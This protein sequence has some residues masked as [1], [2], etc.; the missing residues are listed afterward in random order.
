MKL[1][2][3]AEDLCAARDAAVQH[4]AGHLADLALASQHPAEPEVLQWLQTETVTR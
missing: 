1:H 2:L 4:A 3:E